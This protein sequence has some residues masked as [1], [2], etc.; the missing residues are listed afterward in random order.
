MAKYYIPISS[1][2]VENLLSTESI[3]PACFYQYRQFGDL[4]RGSQRFEEL[5]DYPEDRLLLFL[6]VP[7]FEVH[8]EER[9]NYPVV[10]EF[11]DDGQLESGR[12][13]EISCRLKRFCVCE[14][15]GTIQL[16]PMNCRLLFFTQEARDMVR[17]ACMSSTN[18]KL[19][20]YFQF[21]VVKDNSDFRL[22]TVLE[23]R[24]KKELWRKFSF[25]EEDYEQDNRLDKAKG[26]IYGY[27][28]GIV[29][30]K[31]QFAARLLKC[32]KEVVDIVGAINSRG[33][34]VTMQD[35]KQLTE[36]SKERMLAEFDK[37]GKGSWEKYVKD[38]G[39][40]LEGV[41]EILKECS[42]YEN[43]LW[44]FCGK[45]EIKLSE[46]Y[47]PEKEREFA[48]SVDRQVKEQI[49]EDRVKMRGCWRSEYLDANVELV[50]M[51]EEKIE[52]KWREAAHVFNCILNR[53]VWNGDAI[54]NLS[55]LRSNRF[56]CATEVTKRVKAIFEGEK[57]LWDGSTE[58]DYF[59]HLRRNISDGERFEL[60]DINN[61]V[62]QSLAAFV[63]KGDDFGELV[64]YL[65]GEA[66]CDYR[67]ALA[68]WGAVNGYWQMS[69]RVFATIDEQAELPVLYKDAY[70]L[71]WKR[72]L[73]GEL[74][75]AEEPKISLNKNPKVKGEK[76]EV[77]G[78]STK[79]KRKAKK[80]TDKDMISV[81][82]FDFRNEQE[83]KIKLGG[84]PKYG[85]GTSYFYN[86]RY[87]WEYAK[88]IVPEKWRNKLK[89]NF[90][91]FVGE[92]RKPPHMRYKYYQN[93]NEK[94]NEDVIRRFCNLQKGKL[95]YFPDELR[96]KMREHLK[97]QYC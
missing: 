45:H 39:C 24:K 3:S 56:E 66:F 17:D 47:K 19:V 23:R 96:E 74:K 65:E 15:Y 27:Y 26:F 78:K 12:K 29:K 36:I 33:G 72:E 80:S 21:D 16:T 5:K 92:M 62:L 79:G 48:D 97:R 68:L 50:M 13:R 43:T 46:L 11:E 35:V 10:V 22:E 75:K 4:P 82:E 9:I 89:E 91:W 40:P 71:L 7:S 1:L 73:E 85:E 41:Q 20:E 30:S 53:I 86:D 18:C 67:Y 88:E 58:Q 42:A 81:P 60:G 70:Q 90:D 64:S 28:M 51:E 2:N 76:I 59:D 93:V 63:L 34:E 31:G 6:R 87:A 57:W 37:K 14:Y 8:D 54:P 49:H 61:V 77:V 83:D 52:E 38:K 25:E 55:V 95:D 32:Q 69:R 94:D 84:T 44:N